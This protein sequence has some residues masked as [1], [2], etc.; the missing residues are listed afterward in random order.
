M[1][2]VYELFNKKDNPFIISS[3]CRTREALQNLEV[4]LEYLHNGWGHRAVHLALAEVFVSNSYL[5]AMYT[6]SHKTKVWSGRDWHGGCAN[7]L[8]WHIVSLEYKELTTDLAHDKQLLLSQKYDMV[9]H[10]R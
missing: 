8:S 7:S 10:V 1:D 6:V 5:Q 4:L 3:C 9:I 2:K